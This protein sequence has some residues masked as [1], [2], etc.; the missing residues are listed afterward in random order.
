MD[1]SASGHE[2]TKLTKYYVV[3][4]VS[5]AKRL[6][7]DNCNVNI[8]YLPTY[9]LTYLLNYLLTLFQVDVSDYVESNEWALLKHPAKKNLH[10]YSC[11]EE[12]YLDLTFK[13]ELK[14]I[15][16]FYNYILVLPCVLLSFLTL[17]IFW[18]PPESPAKILLGKRLST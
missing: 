9:L 12:P 6:F 3:F 8:Y 15:A 10:Y 7:Y 2:A 16:V 14:R 5:G 13:V 11:C 4:L 18:L 1:L 17:V